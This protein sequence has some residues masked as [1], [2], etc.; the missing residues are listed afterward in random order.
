VDALVLR[1]LGAF[2]PASVT[3]V[4]LWSGL[5]RLGEVVER[6]PLRTFHGQA[7][8]TLYDL[9]DAPRPPADMPAPP[10]FLP[11]Y[12]NL[13]L[14]HRDRT[15]LILDNRP[16]PLPPGNGATAGTFLVDGKW[17]GTWQIRDQTLRIEPF[18]TLR[19]ADRDA[20]LTEAARLCAFIA[21]QAEYDIV[22]DK[23]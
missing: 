4:Q 1:Y 2:G 3:D 14:S 10:R 22:L 19:H 6:L 16:V 11:E 12:D 13:L 15:R 18:T 8:Q 17:Q 9:S 7:G 5:T 21:P 23:P 20:L